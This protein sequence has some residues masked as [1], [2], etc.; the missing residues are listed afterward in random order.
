MKVKRFKKVQRYL[1]FYKN[2]YGFR[3]PYHVLIDGTFCQ[4]ALKNKVNLKEQIPNYLGEEVKLM[5]TVCT[6]IETEKLGPALYGAML[7]VKQFP[8]RKCGHEKNPVSASECLLSLLKENNNSDHYILATQDTSLSANARQLPGCP[9]LYLKVNSINMEKP[10]AVSETVAK[11]EVETVLAPEEYE[12]ESLKQ[13]KKDVLGEVPS[14]RKRKGPKGPNPLSVKK[15]KNP[16][17]AAPNDASKSSR[18]KKRPAKLKFPKQM[19][20]LLEQNSEKI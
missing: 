11:T 17:Q 19:T 15:K 16:G 5:T 7:V 4:L 3:K 9:I 6:V 18:R 8:V 13:L 10:S 12:V 14:K 2:N 20:K 1:Q